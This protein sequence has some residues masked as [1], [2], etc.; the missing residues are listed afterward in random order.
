MGK[1]SGTEKGRNIKRG[2]EVVHIIFG[3]FWAKKLALL[4]IYIL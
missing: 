3:L 1:M 4:A 2:H